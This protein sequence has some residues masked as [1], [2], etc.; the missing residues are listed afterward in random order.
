MEVCYLRW[1]LW[2]RRWRAVNLSLH[3]VD[4]NELVELFHFYL[5]T[6]PVR[7]GV[8]GSKG[9]SRPCRVHVQGRYLPPSY[10]AVALTACVSSSR[11]LL[12]QALEIFRVTLDLRRFPL[13]QLGGHAW[14]YSPTHR[15]GQLH[16]L[17]LG[18]H[19]QES[20]LHVALHLEILIM[21]FKDP[22]RR[23]SQDLV[24]EGL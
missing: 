5:P 2:D 14:I 20:V 21:P 24:L 16:Q 1:L 8:S 6:H 7:G 13:F 22:S 17:V 12:Q 19:V 23:I 10:R 9:C 11:A 4:G 15:F 18:R 3:V